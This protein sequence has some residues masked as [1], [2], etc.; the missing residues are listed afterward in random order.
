MIHFYIPQE[1]ARVEGVILELL[2]ELVTLVETRWCS[3]Y[4]T[5]VWALADHIKINKLT[6]K[7]KVLWRWKLTNADWEYL[8]HLKVLLMK[9]EAAKILTLYMVVPVFNLVMDRLED[10]DFTGALVTHQGNPAFLDNNLEMEFLGKGSTQGEMEQYLEEPQQG[11]DQD[12]LKY[13]RLWNDLLGHQWIARTIMGAPGS[14]AESE[15]IFSASKE[16]ST[17]SETAFTFRLEAEPLEC[18]RFVAEMT[19]KRR[20]KISSELVDAMA[21]K[22]TKIK[23]RWLSTGVKVV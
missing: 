9:V 14:S 13:W 3:D 15:Q 17:G 10:A 16:D 12:M 11:K 1:M 6:A 4:D 7:E 21:G 23:I 2:K 20:V 19:S 5:I 8:K 22:R 18:A